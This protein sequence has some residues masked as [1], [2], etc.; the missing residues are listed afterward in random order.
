MKG[1]LQAVTDQIARTIELT[2]P[3]E[4]NHEQN[5]ALVRIL[6]QGLLADKRMG[7][8]IAF[9]NKADSKPIMKFSA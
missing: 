9:P 8:E 2:L 7:A 3:A 4:L 5:I 1:K 6:V